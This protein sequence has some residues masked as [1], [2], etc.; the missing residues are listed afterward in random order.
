[1][2]RRISMVFVVLVSLGL[3]LISSSPLPQ[4]AQWAWTNRDSLVGRHGFYFNKRQWLAD[5][6]TVAAGIH[7]LYEFKNF[8]SS[9]ANPAPPPKALMF[10]N[11]PDVAWTASSSRANHRLSRCGSLCVHSRL[12]SVNEWPP[13]FAVVESS[14]NGLTRPRMA[15]AEAR[16][17]VPLSGKEILQQLPRRAAMPQADLR[18]THPDTCTA[19]VVGT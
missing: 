6:R 12:A 7:F 5:V 16:S 3:F 11:L 15:D 2:K 18:D 1:M 8:E 19:T 14:S 17:Y 10:T 4:I 9:P 13:M